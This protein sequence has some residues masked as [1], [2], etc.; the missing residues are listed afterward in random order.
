MIPGKSF[1]LL[2]IFAF[3][4]TKAEAQYGCAPS[5]KLLKTKK[6]FDLENVNQIPLTAA[7]NYLKGKVKTVT[8]KEFNIS[9]KD[10]RPNIKLLDTGY[11]VYDKEGH[12]VDQNTYTPDAS[13]DLHCKY[14]YADSRLQEWAITISG[15][16]KADNKTTFKYDKKGLKT[17]SKEVDKD[18]TKNNRTTY[19][20]DAAGNET[21]E[22]LYEAKGDLKRVTT[23][24]YDD[25]GNQIEY[26][27]KDSKGKLILKLTCEYDKNGFKVSGATYKPESDKPTKWTRK[28]DGE[29]RCTEMTDYNADGSFKTKTAYTYDAKE[30]VVQMLYYKENGSIDE[31]GNNVFRSFEYDK[32]GNITNYTSYKLVGGK[33]IPDGYVETRY[34]YYE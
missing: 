34:T 4:L 15:F 29:G 3:S 1:W 12:L 17:E 30:N 6:I 28:N 7:E 16:M 21:E 23:Y 18:T 13:Y 10:G 8:Y 22:R 27:M 5:E 9:E 33:R 31:N 26:E 20:Y 2:L 19:K 14:T 24:K 11:N 32:A 25:R